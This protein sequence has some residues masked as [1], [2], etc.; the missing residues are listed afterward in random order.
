MELKEALATLE[1]HLDAVRESLTPLR[2][3]ADRNVNG[4]GNGGSPPTAEAPKPAEPAKPAPTR[5]DVQ[6]ISE[7]I[8]DLQAKCEEAEENLR[9]MTR[10]MAARQMELSEVEGNFTAAKAEL[11]KQKE[12]QKALHEEQAQLE[13]RKEEIRSNAEALRAEIEQQRAE[14]E[15]ARQAGLAAQALTEKLFPA[16][17]LGGPLVEWR[18]KIQLAALSPKATPAESLLFASLHGYRASLLESD[19]RF[20]M[21]SLREVS[22]RLYQWLRDGDHGEGRAA[23]IAYQWAQAINAECQGK[24]EVE[25]PFPGSAASSNWMLFRPRPGVSSPDVISVQT[26][27]VRNAQKQPQY[28]AEV[29]V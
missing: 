9:T 24:C 7:E 4:N 17:L 10:K 15:A 27:C 12:Q 25:V 21:E 3:A 1:K 26:W 16:W 23:E 2:E 11:D 13:R 6:A 20:L 22:R 18:E 8:L 19:P 14:M 28:R 5:N 29:T